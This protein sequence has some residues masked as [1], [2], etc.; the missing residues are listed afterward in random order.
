[1][2]DGVTSFSKK[3]SN[4]GRLYEIYAIGS[5]L[6]LYVR[7]AFWLTKHQAGQAVRRPFF[8]IARN[9]N[10]F[11]CWKLG[12]KI[13]AQS[14]VAKSCVAQSWGAQSWWPGF[15]SEQQKAKRLKAEELKAEELKAEELKAE[16]FK[17]N[18]RLLNEWFK[19]ENKAEGLKE[20]GSKIWGSKLKGSIL[21]HGFEDVEGTSSINN[22]K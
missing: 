4:A 9:K 20:R 3:S 1:M 17:T 12:K 22:S 2:S 13:K 14:C 16:W 6:F 8:H 7:S 21:T 10:L 5:R 15:K 18:K 19:I 11:R